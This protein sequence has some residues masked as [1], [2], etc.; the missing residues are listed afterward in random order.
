MRQTIK[1]LVI[2]VAIFATSLSFDADASLT[3]QG[4]PKSGG[5]GLSSYEL[6]YPFLSF[7]PRLGSIEGKMPD[8]LS[9]S[10]LPKPSPGWSE[11]PKAVQRRDEGPAL[12]KAAPAQ[13]VRH[14]SQMGPLAD[15]FASRTYE[16]LSYPFLDLFPRL[17][18]LGALT[19]DPASPEAFAALTRPFAGWP[20]VSVEVLLPTVTPHQA[21]GEEIKEASLPPAEAVAPERRAVPDAA[22]Q[23]QVRRVPMP[24]ARPKRHVPRIAFASPT[25][26]PLAHTRFCL[27]YP[28]D[29]RVQN[30]QQGDSPV[31][32][33]EQR[34]AELVRVNAKVNHAIRPVN[35]HEPVA[36]EKWLIAPKS[37][38]CNDYAVTKRHELLG[39]GWPAHALLLAEVVTTWGEHHL[40]LVVRTSE[41]DLVADNL[42]KHIRS[43]TKTPYY[44][45][46]VETPNNPMFWST[47]QVSQP[48]VVAMA[49]NGRRL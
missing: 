25:L 5:S 28:A 49:G 34:R 4:S 9:L 44:W 26:A 35:P 21:K 8:L 32:L 7:V 18:S 3:P 31:E 33:N 2:A 19:S 22:P 42:A 37:G 1:T 43:W 30:T 17:S 11:V 46:R 45:V 29:C 16:A 48:S 10:A 38:D 24:L 47:L 40:V 15:E 27:K 6:S 13:Q 39:L 41:G 20:S 36:A 12:S 14:T 23:E